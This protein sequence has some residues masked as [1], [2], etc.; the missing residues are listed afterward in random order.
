M[1]TAMSGWPSG[2]RDAQA[3]RFEPAA[4]ASELIA[5][6]GFEGVDPGGVLDRENSSARSTSR[7]S[8]LRARGRASKT[9][10]SSLTALGRSDCTRQ[11]RSSRQGTALSAR[12]S[13]SWKDRPAT[14]ST[15]PRRAG[16]WRG[17]QSRRS[18]FRRDCGLWRVLRGNRSIQ[19]RRA[20]RRGGRGCRPFRDRPPCARPWWTFPEPVRA[21]RPT[22]RGSNGLTRGLSTWK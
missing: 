12:R 3:A 11:P 22:K 13:G 7:S 17:C 14:R 8:G 6:G 15:S 2:R 21:C 20:S 10:I 18:A 1:Y 16:A 19:R 5:S 9:N 4:G